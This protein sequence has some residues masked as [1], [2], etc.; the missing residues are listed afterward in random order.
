MRECV[1]LQSSPVR[2]NTDGAQSLG[3]KPNKDKTLDLRRAFVSFSCDCM[4]IH[5]F[6][7]F[8]WI[9]LEIFYLC[10]MYIFLCDHLPLLSNFP[11]W[12]KTSV[13]AFSLYSNAAALMN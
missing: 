12:P 3:Y 1:T 4:R 9:I 7:R 11:F 2:T 13:R 10:N 8:Y 6:L 5:T